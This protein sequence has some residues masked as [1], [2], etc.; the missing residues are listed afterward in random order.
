LADESITKRIVRFVAGEDE[1]GIQPDASLSPLAVSSPNCQQ[2]LRE[3]AVEQRASRAS[4]HRLR[5]SGRVE[6]GRVIGTD[7]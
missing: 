1:E 6:E 7:R 5:K 2:R 3:G 4:V